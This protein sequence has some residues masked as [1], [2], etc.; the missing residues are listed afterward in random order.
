MSASDKKMCG[1]QRDESAY[2]HV[3]ASGDAKQILSKALATTKHRKVCVSL[4]LDMHII[5]YL[6]KGKWK[7]YLSIQYLTCPT[8]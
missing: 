3:L 5:Q 8:D 2:Q 6:P 7:F 1:Y 4:Q